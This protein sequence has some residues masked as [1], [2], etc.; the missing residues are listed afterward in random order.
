MRRN[1]NLARAGLLATATAAV[2][3]A[4]LV[5]AGG[6]SAMVGVVPATAA[7]QS[8]PGTPGSGAEAPHADPGQKERKAKRPAGTAYG[9]SL[10]GPVPIS[11]L[12]SVTSTAK[13]MRRALLNQNTQYVGAKAVEAGAAGRRADS[14]ITGLRVP[15]A[16]LTAETISSRCMGG[17]G[18]ARLVNAMM[19][20]E[21]LVSDPRPN[22]TI[23]VDIPSVGRAWVTLNK[24]QRLPDGRLAVT[25]M[26]TSLP[27][28]PLG[29]ETL[30]TAH[31]VCGKSG[32][33]SYGPSGPSSGGSKPG[34]AGGPA[35]S[36]QGQAHQESAY[37]PADAAAPAAP[38]PSPVRGNLPV[39]G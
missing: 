7:V 32:S 17:K 15:A 27:L 33:G 29:R 19:A 11:P 38:K 6:V 39:T 25:G 37:G 8:H 12:P 18:E 2:T 22:T 4:S 5:P 1:K 16:G 28:G 26:E 14:T 35:G 36:G 30:R 21:R 3:G 10:T 24:Q 13:E 23:P 31:A 9:L 34:G 20:G